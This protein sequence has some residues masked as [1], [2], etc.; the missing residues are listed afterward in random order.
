MSVSGR[1]ERSRSPLWSATTAA[2]VLCAVLMTACG[3]SPKA[4]AA[5]TSTA[6]S[7]AT[8]IPAATGAPSGSASGTLSCPSVTE[9]DD[10]LGQND[11]G[12]VTSGTAQ[13][14]VC[15]YKGSVLSAVVTISVGTP[16]AFHASEQDVTSHGLTVVT[17]PGLGDEAWA[18]SG[19]GEVAVLKGS[20][21]VEVTSPPST[22]AQV[23]ALA[24]AII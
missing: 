21:E 10:A 2:L 17:V 8:T 13:Y 19:S 12:P 5:T 24:R 4:V 15:T 9:V 7:G 18:T 23:E 11:T 20:T 1:P 14:R 16:A 6:P 3:S 22:P